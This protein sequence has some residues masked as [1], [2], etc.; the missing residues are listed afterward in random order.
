MRK[1]IFF[2]NLYLLFTINLNSQSIYNFSKITDRQLKKIGV[3]KYNDYFVVARKNQDVFLYKSSDNGKSWEIIFKDLL[4]L[5]HVPNYIS[6][7]SVRDSTIIL[8]TDSSIISCTTDLGNTWNIQH[9]NLTKSG[10]FDLRFSDMA[11]SKIGCASTVFEIVL[12]EDAW[13]TYHTLNIPD[14]MLISDDNDELFL[15][16][17]SMPDENTIFI[18]AFIKNSRYLTKQYLLSSIDRGKTWKRTSSGFN[19]LYSKAYNKDFVIACGINEFSE[20]TNSHSV[21]YSS[22]DRGETWKTLFDTVF[23]KIGAKNFNCLRILDSLNFAM[24]LY[25]KLILTNDGAKTLNFI[26]IDN[27]F[28]F[29]PD[30]YFIK[31]DSIIILSQNDYLYKYNPNK[32]NVDDNPTTINNIIYFPNPSRDV[33]NIKLDSEPIANEELEIYDLMGL[34][35]LSQKIDNIQ[36]NIDIQKLNT[37]IYYCKLKQSGTVFKFEVVK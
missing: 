26:Q 31:K 34:N 13:K 35:L 27:G 29:S 24:T 4:N 33:L 10:P 9:L 8:T 12:T 1:L 15:F 36:T 14:S 3:N 25:D 6:S 22:T 18:T 5:P 23:Y 17:P 21:A 11:T 20:T 37:G 16:H 7:L 30:F 19:I 32:T 28:S 2:I